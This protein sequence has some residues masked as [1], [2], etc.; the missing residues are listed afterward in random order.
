MTF[1][2]FALSILLFFMSIAAVFSFAF[3]SFRMPTILWNG[4][5]YFIM[6]ATVN[7]LF[8]EPSGNYV[9]LTLMAIYL[10]RAWQFRHL[11]RRIWTDWIRYQGVKEDFRGNS[12]QN[13]GA[14]PTSRTNRV[15]SP[16]SSQNEPEVID[17]EFEVKDQ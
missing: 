9:G 2:E 1:G 4:F 7:R 17:V 13:N 3:P 6:G 5:W 11:K 15:S 8:G 10:I 12:S 14:G 16:S